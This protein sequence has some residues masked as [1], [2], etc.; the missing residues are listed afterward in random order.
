MP[1][2]SN[3]ILTDGGVYDNLDLYPAL[4]DNLKRAGV[5][6]IDEKARPIR[7]EIVREREFEGAKVDLGQGI[8]GALSLALWYR[9]ASADAAAQPL[10]AEISF[11]Y[12]ID[13]GRVDQAVAR[14]VQQLFEGHARRSRRLVRS[15][16]Y[17]QDAAGPAAGMP[18][19]IGGTTW[20]RTPLLHPKI[21]PT[22]HCATYLRRAISTT[23]IS[24]AVQ[25]WSQPR[26][27]VYRI[28]VNDSW[29]T[30]K[31]PGKIHGKYPRTLENSQVRVYSWPSILVFVKTMGEPSELS[32]GELV[33]KIH[34]PS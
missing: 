24:C 31:G 8:N 32:P 16:S 28:R 23:Y 12:D 18:M 11:K 34:R 25:T 3:V 15:D 33:P 17:H 13:G 6:Q 14:R 21:S 9:T 4:H 2:T 19:S 1:F 5:S 30:E 22:S 7:G 20:R 29:P 27:G 26:S 10:T